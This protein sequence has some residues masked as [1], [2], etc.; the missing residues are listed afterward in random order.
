[1]K[2]P[3]SMK[4]AALLAIF[5]TIIVSVAFYIFNNGAT[6][7]PDPAAE[8]VSTREGSA[9]ASALLEKIDKISKNDRDD[10]V[11][12]YRNSEDNTLLKVSLNQAAL[13]DADGAIEFKRLDPPATVATLRSR[14]EEL[15]APQGVMPV[16]YQNGEQNNNPEPRLVTSD[17]LAK[18]P[19]DQAELLAQKHGLVI[20]ARPPYA[21]EYVVFSAAQPLEAL[22]KIEGIRG[23]NF[24]ETA[25]VLLSVN[26][27]KRALPNDPFVGNQWHLKAS[28]G[29]VAGSDI[30]VENA[31]KFGEANGV[32]GAGVAISIVDDGMQTSHP[33]LSPNAD[34]N[35]DYDFN[36]DDNDPSPGAGDAHGTACAGVAAARGNNGVGVTGVSPEAD[37]IGLRLIS[38]FFTNQDV[39]D[40]LS[41]KTDLVDISSNSWGPSDDGSTLGGASDLARLSLKSAAETGREGKGTIFIWAG[42]NGGVSATNGLNYDNSNYDSYANSIYTIAVGATSSFGLRSFYS[43]PGANILICAPSNGGAL[44]IVTTDN[45]GEAGY[46]G[47]ASPL[48]ANYTDTF[49]G[50]SSA[51]PAVAGAIGLM[52]E[53]NPDLG[54]R[55][56]QEI[57]VQTAKKVDPTNADWITNGAG[58]DFNHNFGAGLIDA[59]AAVELA[60]TWTNL[61]E[62]ISVS[63]PQNNINVTI[64]NNNATGITREFDLTASDIR[65]EHVT[66]LVD[67][68]HQR[69]GELAVSLTSPSGT[70]SR[71]AEVHGDRNANYSAWTFSTVRCWGE[72][73]R[74]TW[75]LNITDTQTGSNAAG[76][77]R[78]TSLTVFGSSAAPVNP[79][80]QLIIT[81]PANGSVISPGVI[82]PVTVTATDFDIDGNNTTNTIK[83][84][85]LFVNG[86]PTEPDLTAPYSFNISPPLGNVTLTA[87]ATDASDN[88]GES[89][90]V[91]I[92][93]A[94]QIPVV[95]SFAVNFGETAFSDQQLSVT[96]VTTSDPEEDPVAVSYQWRFTTN[97]ETY[98]DQPGAVTKDLPLSPQNAGKTWVCEIRASDASNV[99]PPTLTNPVN[100]LTRPPGQITP[101]SFFSY[102]SGLVLNGSDKEITRPAIIHEFS[103]G[104]QGALSDSEWVEILIMQDSDLSDWTLTDAEGNALL[105]LNNGAWADIPAGTLIVIYNGGSQKDPL[106]PVESFDPSSRKIILSS[107]NRSYFS[108]NRAIW[109]N[110]GNSGDSIFLKD[111]SEE[112]IHSIAFGNSTFTTPNLGNVSG[113]QATYF[114]GQEDLAANEASNWKRTDATNSSRSVSGASA[115]SRTSL[116][117]GIYSENF[118]AIPGE[119]GTSYPTGWTSYNQVTTGTTSTTEFNAM[120]LGSI[121]SF[122]ARNYNFGSK[123]GLLG[124]NNTPGFDPSYISF[125]LDHTSRLSDLKISYDVVKI[126]EEARSMDF[127]LEYTTS[128]P[129]NTSTA[130]IPITGGSHS[131]GNSASGT[132]TEYRNISLPAAFNNRETPIH[133]RWF[134]RTTAG[135]GAGLRDSLAI[136]NV[137]ISSAQ[138]GSVFL[139]LNFQPDTALENAGITSSLGSVTSHLPVQ[140]DTIIRLTSS[141]TDL[142]TVPATVLLRAGETVVTFPVGVIN[143]SIVDGTRSVLIS[144]ESTGLVG[145]AKTFFV[146]D[147]EEVTGGVSP[148]LPNGGVNDIFVSQLR[149][150]VLKNP[151][152]FSLTAESVLPNGLS[153][154]PTT[155]TISGNVALD[156]APG[157]YPI[158]IQLTNTLGGLTSQTLS[159]NVSSG[160]ASFTDWI[161]GFVVT[162]S[163]VTGDPDFDLFPNFLEYAMGTNPA[164][165]EV[166]SPV[167]FERDG[168]EIHITYPE[169]K[170]LPNVVV[171]AEW[172]P[173][174]ED[175][176][177]SSEGVTT[178]IM[179]QDDTKW[180][181]KAS[182]DVDPLEPKRF[183]RL[184]VVEL[185]AG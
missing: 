13:V 114:A 173:S 106:V 21:P 146:A 164:L 50:T 30:N 174:M 34:T 42:G 14:L 93:V 140:T 16:V 163:S 123:I 139:S 105:F 183:M 48:G 153:L 120:R 181:K 81:N 160:L 176:T 54:W 147:D 78:S 122:L 85:Q 19:K 46:A 111:S 37:L 119:T 165:F 47:A 149:S 43:E 141:N 32:K 150:G 56:V 67:I 39:A 161:A 156:A 171:I 104:S 159:L 145:D 8:S 4:P 65:V 180:I 179:S 31:W 45:T 151:P 94:N 76:T 11:L 155:G 84:V 175:G 10:A 98:I 74:G 133:L 44:G 170:D 109:P 127:I 73:S 143:N 90:S 103:Q 7:E 63:S 113:F 132:V 82:V 112:E 168:D 62:Q 87:R 75:R 142:V 77:L 131:S 97:L 79:A 96:S 101:G 152:T 41:W 128:N 70:V 137:S 136:D 135:S 60:D 12:E 169:L 29:A 157:S 17:I 27:V 86:I 23:E 166:P 167:I 118:D 124:S 25:D 49:G 15:E 182:L 178:V 72:N 88:I 28:N 20:K 59:T 55:D 35:N 99:S 1:M 185:P 51:T 116:D 107:A 38:G 40:A 66:V 2:K 22:E 102:T 144:A 184:R 36:G 130:W 100:I 95:E 80:P 53:K 89:A 52:L 154:D 83:N 158:T 126:R 64:P 18:L 92:F 121:N 3:I 138:A 125:T 26:V 108:P 148:S 6:S 110:F 69:R 61:G 115:K 177:W 91:S 57:L 134:Y 58:F 172:S 129:G 68:E 24:V 117:F 71:L 5:L 9:E 33:D 162:D